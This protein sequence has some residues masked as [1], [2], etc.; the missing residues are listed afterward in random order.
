MFENGCSSS[1]IA[2]LH[3]IIVMFEDF[4]LEEIVK[5]SA[6][7]QCRGLQDFLISTL[8]ILIFGTMRKMLPIK[9]LQQL[10]MI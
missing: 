7:N 8:L 1:M 3:I 6:M 5:S 10:E 4:S 2:R 9:L